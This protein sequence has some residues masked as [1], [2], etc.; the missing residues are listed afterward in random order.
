VEVTG[1]EEDGFCS[2]ECWKRSEWVRRSGMLGEEGRWL[3]GKDGTVDGDKGKT[4]ELLEE[5]EERLERERKVEEEKEMERRA[6]EEG[7]KAREEEVASREKK[8]R[9]VAGSVPAFIATR[10]TDVSSAPLGP[11]IPAAA[12]TPTSSPPTPSSIIPTTITSSSSSP[13]PPALPLSGAAALIASLTI[14]ERPTPSLLPQ[15]PSLSPQPPTSNASSSSSSPKPSSSTLKIGSSPPPMSLKTAARL[16]EE[17]RRADASAGALIPGSIGGLGR[18]G[19]VLVG[20]S[21]GGGGKGGKK[22]EKS[23]GSAVK[24]AGDG[25]VEGS[26]GGEG[27]EGGEAAVAEEEEEEEDLDGLKDVWEEMYKARGELEEEETT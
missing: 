22:F 6:W 1:N 15:P 12:A 10:P 9:S 25:V 8:Q 24:K 2:K 17:R 20:A 13:T 14:K 21:S 5:V 11:P 7:E 3:R 26:E 4:W 16:K 19:D 18:M 27:E 23:A